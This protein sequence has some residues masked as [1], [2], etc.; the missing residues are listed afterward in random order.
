V[1]GGVTLLV[2]DLKFSGRKAVANA[3]DGGKNGGIS[4]V[5][6][7]PVKRALVLFGNHKLFDIHKSVVLSVVVYRGTTVLYCVFLKKSSIGKR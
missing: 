3:S 2:N 7:D 6:D 4:T 1:V 5:T